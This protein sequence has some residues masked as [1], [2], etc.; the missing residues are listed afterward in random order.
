MVEIG[1][2]GDGRFPG[3]IFYSLTKITHMGAPQGIRIFTEMDLELLRRVL[4][5]SEKLSPSECGSVGSR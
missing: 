2:P 5:A 1:L 3:E 4:E